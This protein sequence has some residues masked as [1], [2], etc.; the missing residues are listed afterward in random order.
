MARSAVRAQAGCCVWVARTE[1]HQ[2]SPGHTGEAVELSK[3]RGVARH[4]CSRGTGGGGVL[5]ANSVRDNDR[6]QFHGSVPRGKR[7][8]GG[9]VL[10]QVLEAVHLP[11]R[12]KPY[13]HVVY[14]VVVP[15]T[16]V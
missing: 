7:V 3:D 11:Q 14:T 8:E 16:R 6:A 9:A 13:V 1:G 10:D 2:G 4:H 12:R 15:S 5:G